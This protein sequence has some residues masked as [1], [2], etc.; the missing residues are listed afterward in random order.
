MLA[1]ISAIAMGLFAVEILSMRYQI[2]KPRL[3]P[4]DCA[5][6]IPNKEEISVR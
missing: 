2:V 5:S 1:A 6:A 4:S 3:N